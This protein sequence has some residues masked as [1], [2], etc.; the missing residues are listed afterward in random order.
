MSAAYKPNLWQRESAP[1]RRLGLIGKVGPETERTFHFTKL[2][3][4]I[5]FYDSTPALQPNR[6][7]AAQSP[8]SHNGPRQ[9]EQEGCQQHQLQVGAC[10]EVRKGYE[11]GSLN[12]MDELVAN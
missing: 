3:K 2:Q 5:F 12:M 4:L 1:P 6:Q 11:H 10:Y 7:V 9:E 8:N